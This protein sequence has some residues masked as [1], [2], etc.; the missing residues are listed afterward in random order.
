MEISASLVKELR[1]QTGA[2][3]MDCKRALV[4]TDGDLDAAKK[5]L[6]ERGAAVAEKRKDRAASAGVVAA[7]M[8]EDRHQAVLLEFTC[9]TDFVARNE[10]FVA[11]ANKIAETALTNA[12]AGAASDHVLDLQ[13]DGKTVKEHISEATGKIGE[14]LD[15]GGIVKKEV[16]GGVLDTYIHHDKTKGV[17][18]EL[19]GAEG[20]S[21]IELAHQ[22]AVHIAWAAPEFISRDQ[23]DQTRIDEELQAEK[24]R[25]LAEGKP[26]AAAQQIAEGRVNKNFFQKVSLMD[27]PYLGGGD[28]IGKMVEDAG[29]GAKVASFV[30]FAVGS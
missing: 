17:L 21:A 29:G 4:E 13:F 1:D 8:S 3:L 16:S 12:P 2:P 5:K 18:V 30:R 20:E 9:E 11:L 22:I 15:M 23:I 14:K 6:R 25:A 27:Q 19:A 26:E 24:E 28:T 7:A 10:D